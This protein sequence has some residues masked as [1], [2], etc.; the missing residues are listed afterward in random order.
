MTKTAKRK[1]KTVAKK[2]AGAVQSVMA[3]ALGAAAVTA[4]GVVLT[5]VA[6]GMGSGAKKLEKQTPAFKTTA[7][8][9]AQKSLAKTKKPIRKKVKPAKKRRKK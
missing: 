7:K 3:E 5:R 9:A 6:E 4:A 8:Q 2:G 1:A